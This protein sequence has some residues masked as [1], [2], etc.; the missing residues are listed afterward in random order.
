M[1]YTFASPVELSP[2][3][4]YWIWLDGTSGSAGVCAG[5]TSPYDSYAPGGTYYNIPTCSM[6]G[7]SAYDITFVAPVSG[8]YYPPTGSS[9]SRT[10]DTTVSTPSWVWSWGNFNTTETDNGGTI[11]YGTESS[12]DG[13]TWETELTVTPGS[14]VRSSPQRYVRYLT[15]FNSPSAFSTPVLSSVTINTFSFERSS[16]TFR[17]Q[18]HAI[19]GINNFGNFS[20]LD[21]LNGGSI[22]FSVCSANNSSMTGAACSVQSPNTQITIATNSYVNFYATFT[23]TSAT[24]TPTLSGTA[25]QWYTGTRSVPM[26]STVWDNRYWLSLTTTTTDSVND[27]VLVLNH[28]GAWTIFDI[29][30]GAF[31]Q[32]KNSLYH[33]DSLGSGNIYLDNQGQGDNGKAINAFIR[34]RELTLGD[35]AADD[36]LY[37]VYPSA[38]NTGICPMTVGYNLDFN[39]GMYSLGTPLLSEFGNMSAVR[40]PFPVDTSHQDFG[41]ALDFT[42]GTD[43]NQ[44]DWQFYG[45]EG[46]FK[47][48]PTQ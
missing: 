8:V 43:D 25:F 45:L 41:Q 30:A 23:V 3:T 36:Y 40:L 37:D 27:S 48:R 33:A 6:S 9:T 1:T 7:S 5:L 47:M 42:V 14:P 38:S 10:F 28:T 12:A 31:T 26:A 29:H 34:T 20:V 39:P 2:S 11:L 32:Y 22:T 21:S 19:G 46:L 44:C 15:L 17:S 16:G 18:S 35:Y 13:S 4:K 24:S